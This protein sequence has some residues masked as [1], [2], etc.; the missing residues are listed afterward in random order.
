MIP[1]IIHQTWKSK[2]VPVRWQGA[3]ESVRRYHPGWRYIL[4][5]DAEMDA[6][7]K[8]H[9]PLLCPIYEGFEKSIMRAD[10]FRYV[11]MHDLGGL[12]CDLDYEFLR[13]FPYGDT[14]LLLSKEFALDYGDA[15]D[16]VANYIFASRSGHPFW[17]DVIADLI[18]NPPIASVYTDVIDA[19]GPGF[20][21]R[22]FFANRERYD[23]VVVTPKP[24]LSPTRLHSSLERK[25]LLNSGVTYGMHYGSGSWKERWSATYI[26]TKLA[27]LFRL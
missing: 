18:A 6:H 4:W 2:T 24:A 13:P 22:V 23:G 21:S 3:V 8:E 26:R 25:I 15:R 16:Q 7:V 20:L 27:K 12:Y 1:K 9:Q 17:K 19:T 10:V 5:T 14:E 11:A